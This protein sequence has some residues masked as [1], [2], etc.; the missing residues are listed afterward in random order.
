MNLLTI[1]NWFK[2]GLRRLQWFF[3]LLGERLKVEFALIKTLNELDKLNHKK[4]DILE[5]IGKRVVELYDYTG[6]NLF[7]DSELKGL[8]EE[9][10]RTEEKI[11]SL[12]DQADE[13]S[14]VED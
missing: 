4:K 8:L 5:R 6:D 1:K 2:A 3:S 7:N 11:A 14:R 13:I 12:K 9:L 10:K